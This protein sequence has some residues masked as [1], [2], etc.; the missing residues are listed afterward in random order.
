MTQHLSQILVADYGLNEE[1]LAEAYRLK[2]E[3]GGSLGEIL[4]QQD[5]ISE[6]QLLEALGNQYELDYWPTLPLDDIESDFTEKIPIQFLKKYFMVP[7]EY[8]NPVTAANCAMV[9]S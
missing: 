4:V 8:V 3:K 9:L 6:A 7:L 5:N 2:D 1:E